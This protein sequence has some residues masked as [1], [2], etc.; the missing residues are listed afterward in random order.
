MNKKEHVIKYLSQSRFSKVEILLICCMVVSAIATFC[1]WWL[2]PLL[3][4][5][6]ALYIF[7]RAPR[8]TDSDYEHMLYQL[9]YNN[10]IKYRFDEEYEAILLFVF[11]PKVEKRKI[12]D[13]TSAA[14]DLTIDNVVYGSDTAWRS[15]QYR[16]Y[17]LHFEENG[18][19]IYSL[20]ADLIDWTVTE[21]THLI[22][23]SCK[24]TTKTQ[25]VSRQG[26]HISLSHLCFGDGLCVPVDRRSMDYPDILKHFNA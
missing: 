12:A 17:N 14:Y 9:F 18:C 15:A 19:R 26:E 8:V 21:Q 16:V 4:A 23:Y 11:H 6:V 2:A 5:T 24:V 25:T 13:Y 10:P 7:L 22:P 1:N 20:C 3:I